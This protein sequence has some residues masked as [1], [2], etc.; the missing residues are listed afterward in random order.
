MGKR[1]K[2]KGEKYNWRGHFDGLPNGRFNEE[3]LSDWYEKLQ[4]RGSGPLAEMRMICAL[5][6]EVAELKGINLFAIAQKRVI[7]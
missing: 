5:I 6:E 2:Y 7:K 1:K 3:I 4:P